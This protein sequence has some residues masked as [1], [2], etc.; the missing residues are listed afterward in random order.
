[1]N[2]SPSASTIPYT[3]ADLA[4]VRAGFVPLE[5]LCDRRGHDAA[6]VRNNIAAGR[7]PRP[8]YVLCGG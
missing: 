7:L 2:A 5:E 3:K 8:T 6:R 4:Y 1:M